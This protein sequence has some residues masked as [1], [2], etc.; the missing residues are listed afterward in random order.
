MGE[1]FVLWKIFFLHSRSYYK[2][3]HLFKIF[4]KNRK[5][6]SR[7]NR[8]KPISLE[9]ANSKHYNPREALSKF[10]ETHQQVKLTWNVKR[11]SI[12]LLRTLAPWM[13][14]L[15]T[16]MKK[17]LLVTIFQKSRRKSHIFFVIPLSLR[18]IRLKS[19]LDR[20]S[21]V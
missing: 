9:G 1:K 15:K 19:N 17:L 5:I 7:K 13:V 21:V 8:W 6:K 2:I 18:K 3:G 11:K 20:K 16:I 10:M 12:T 4:P 14:L